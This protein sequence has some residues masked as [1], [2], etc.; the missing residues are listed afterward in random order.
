MLEILKC[1]P[2][3]VRWENNALRDVSGRALS[4]R[5]FVLVF[6]GGGNEHLIC[7]PGFAVINLSQYQG[8]IMRVARGKICI[9]GS[10]MG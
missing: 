7:N 2:H 3:G 5:V 8:C 1:C 9:F 6:L 10:A 4:F